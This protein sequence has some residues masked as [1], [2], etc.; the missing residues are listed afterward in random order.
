MSH[1]GGAGEGKIEIAKGRSSLVR[2]VE[3]ARK[4]GKQA[5]FCGETERQSKIA[6]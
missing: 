5:V 1:L 2:A 4:R 6:G 3:F